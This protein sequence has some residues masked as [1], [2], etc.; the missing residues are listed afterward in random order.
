MKKLKISE[1]TTKEFLSNPGAVANSYVLINYEDN[2]TEAPVTYKA[3]VDELGKAIAEN[4]KLYK[5]DNNGGAQTIS[6]GNN[7]YTNNTAKSFVTAAEKTKIANAL[8]QHQDISG[9]VDKVTGKGLST[10][11]YTDADK[12]KVTN[13]ISGSMA[14][15]AASVAKETVTT[16]PNSYGDT[17]DLNFT[18]LDKD[19]RIW[20]FDPT[21]NDGSGKYSPVYGLENYY[22]NAM[23]G[24]EVTD[25]QD[26]TYQFALVDNQGGL[27]WMVYDADAN[28]QV[29]T[30][31]E[32][33]GSGS[34]SGSS[35]PPANC[36]YIYNPPGENT[37]LQLR[38]GSS[39]GT[40]LG[41]KIALD[42]A[43]IENY[44]YTFML[45]DG[46]NHMFKYVQASDGPEINQIPTPVPY[47]KVIEHYSSADSTWN[48]VFYGSMGCYSCLM[49]L[50]EYNDPTPIPPSIYSTGSSTMQPMYITQATEYV[51]PQIG[52][53]DDYGNFRELNG[54][55]IVPS[56]IKYSLQTGNNSFTD[57]DYV[58]ARGYGSDKQFYVLEA[59]EGV[60][61]RLIGT[62]LFFTLDTTNNKILLKNPDGQ[63]IGQVDYAPVASQA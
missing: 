39:S 5:D 9:K 30:P 37:V 45:V 25:V 33:G 36:Y 29:F 27:G 38:R 63:T 56:P 7:T 58:F 59:S 48:C 35:A 43:E 57:Y 31:I 22:A 52:Y 11:D 55:D 23:V 62:P 26:N 47:Q 50:D 4:L 42:G 15:I 13:A 16:P 41:V 6:A 18:L 17:W 34:G 44:A 21:L 3:T 8:T 49:T 1:L 54:P 10:N 24:M 53:F 40:D 61:P 32:T 51:D 28:G 19:M 60:I 2:T 12:L 46:S 20:T 14:S